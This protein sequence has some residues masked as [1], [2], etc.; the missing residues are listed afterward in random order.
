MSNVTVIGSTQD[1]DVVSFRITD[2]GFIY[3]YGVQYSPSQK[4]LNAIGREC[5]GGKKATGI[6]TVISHGQNFLVATF[7]SVDAK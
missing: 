7:C 4:G 3:Y 5:M 1:E 6:H 2:S